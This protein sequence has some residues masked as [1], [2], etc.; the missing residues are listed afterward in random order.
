MKKSKILI[1]VEGGIVQSVMSTDTN[2]QFVI[3]DYDLK[4]DE[5]VIV[6]DP[7]KPEKL[8]TENFYELFTDEKDPI[9]ME[10]RDKLKRLKF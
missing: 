6:S 5:P 10:V 7:T 4:G 8:K 9:D 2:I 1:T 3:V